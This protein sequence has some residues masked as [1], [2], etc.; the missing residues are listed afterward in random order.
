VARFLLPPDLQT[1]RAQISIFPQTFTTLALAEGSGVGGGTRLSIVSTKPN[2]LSVP[3]IEK[4]R[5]HGTLIYFDLFYWHEPGV[6]VRIEARLGED[7]PVWGYTD[8]VIVNGVELQRPPVVA[9]I[10]PWHCWAAAME[11]YFRVKKANF[12]WTRPKLLEAFQTWEDGA[13]D[14]VLQ[15]P[16]KDS[17]RTVQGLYGFFGIVHE[18]FPADKLIFDRIAGRF[19]NYGYLLI[20]TSRPI[21][22]KFISHSVVLYG[23]DYSSKSLHVMDPSSG[24]AYNIR[25][26]EQFSGY[27]AVVIARLP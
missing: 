13:L 26:A 24:G 27:N 25:T 18:V 6:T 10:E 19:R 20:T 1:G 21:G 5:L 8:I 12:N 11:S 3:G 14:P 22:N 15:P 17:K 7:G 16:N 23:V 2:V 4:Q 9:Q